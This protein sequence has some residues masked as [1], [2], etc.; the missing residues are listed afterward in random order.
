[1]SH[2]RGSNW[3]LGILLAN[4]CGLTSVE[5]DDAGLSHNDFCGVDDSGKVEGLADLASRGAFCAA[6]AL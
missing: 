1:M 6:I 4:C 5:G 2:S 3:C